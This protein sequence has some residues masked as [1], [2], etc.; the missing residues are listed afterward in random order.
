MPNTT[1]GGE[2]LAAKMSVKEL[3]S[4]EWRAMGDAQG[5]AL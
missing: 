3:G 5:R 4:Y 2:T 1:P